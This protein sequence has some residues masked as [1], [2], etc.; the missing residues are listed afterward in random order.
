MDITDIYEAARK[1]GLTRSQRH[2]S[3]MLLG[4]AH[5]YLADKAGECSAATLLNLYRR[6]GELGEVD[7]QAMA[8][9]RLLNA[10]ASSDQR[11]AVVRP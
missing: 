10:E 6:L 8:F 2:F 3:A 7:L 9:R 1:R 4:R 11:R 5:N